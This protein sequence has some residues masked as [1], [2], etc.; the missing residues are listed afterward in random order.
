MTGSVDPS[1]VWASMD[2]ANEWLKHTNCYPRSDKSEQ[3]LLNKV[4]GRN[5]ESILEV[6]AGNGRLIGALSKRYLEC[7]SVD[8]NKKMSKFVADKYKIKTYVGDVCDLPLA[9]KSFDLVYTFQVLQHVE[10]ERIHKAVKELKRVANTVWL[11]EG[12]VDHYYRKDKQYKTGI[13]TH[14][15]D[16]GSFAYYFDDMEVG[17]KYSEM[18]KFDDWEGKIKFYEI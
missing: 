13:K 6:G 3:Y 4:K 14:N 15:I 11:I 17:V 9:D 7:Y 2:K 1:R 18:A 10:P 8:I 12:F 16:G 5:F